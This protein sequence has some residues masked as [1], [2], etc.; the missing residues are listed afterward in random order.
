MNVTAQNWLS[1]AC[2]SL[3]VAACGG[4]G[5]ESPSSPSPSPAPA[6]APG[7]SPEPSPAPSPAPPPA[8]ASAPAAPNVGDFGGLYG[9]GRSMDGRTLLAVLP[10]D[11]LWIFRESPTF[12]G[13]PSSYSFVKT[14]LNKI[15]VTATTIQKPTAGIVPVG[16]PVLVRRIDDTRLDVTDI[17]P[18]PT[19]DAVPHLR[20][21]TALYDYASPAR[22]SDA[23]GSWSM[24][25][26]NTFWTRFDL[27]VS[28]SGGL[29]STTTYCSGLHGRL[30]PD[31]RNKNLYRFE[32]ATPAGCRAYPLDSVRGAAIV[33]RLPSG[34]QQLLLLSEYFVAAGVRD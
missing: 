11:Q 21:A 16:G 28:A 31:P 14:D 8:P 2:L 19:S 25:F 13:L 17:S 10:D 34:Q 4:G 18:L 20:L 27:S 5:A 9:A 30:E 15:V 33:H 24:Y 32:L 23:A 1:I 6:P 26:D 22:L 7:P 3:L 12:A 29:S